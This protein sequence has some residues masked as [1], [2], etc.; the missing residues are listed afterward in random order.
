MMMLSPP[1]DNVNENETYNEVE[2]FICIDLIN[3]TY[4]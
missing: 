4:I 3:I 2:N 1:Y